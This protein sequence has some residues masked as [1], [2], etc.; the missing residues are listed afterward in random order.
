MCIRDR[1]YWL[2]I[3]VIMGIAIGILSIERV[4]RAVKPVYQ[5]IGVLVPLAIFVLVH[6]FQYLSWTPVGSPVIEGVFGRY[7]LSV[8]MLA[9]PYLAMRKWPVLSIKDVRATAAFALLQLVLAASTI[10]VLLDRYYL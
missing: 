1:P 7:F 8:A 6:V 9:L 2:R 5:W 3:L 10:W 4:C